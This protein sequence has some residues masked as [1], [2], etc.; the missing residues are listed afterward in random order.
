MGIYRDGWTDIEGRTYI[1]T[2]VDNPRHGLKFGWY[3][4]NSAGSVL[5]DF[6]LP[7]TEP[8]VIAARRA[9]EHARHL[10]MRQ[11]KIVRTD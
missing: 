2:R 1:L 4:I 7:L 10:G 9:G 3:L 5:P 6:H 11:T 8:E